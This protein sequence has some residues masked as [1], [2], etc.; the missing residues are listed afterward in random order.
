MVVN[1]FNTVLGEQLYIVGDVVELGANDN[2]KALG[3]IFNA[4]QS[5]AQYPNWFYD[6]NLPINKTINCHLVKK[7]SSGKVL[8]LVQ[9]PIPLKLIARLK[10]FH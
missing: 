6:V 2:H 1:N 9:K 5:I 7:D 10:P 4:T 3:P 8:G